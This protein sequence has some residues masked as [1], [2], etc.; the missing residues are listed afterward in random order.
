MIDQHVARASG[1]GSTLCETHGA[2]VKRLSS[3]IM[4]AMG[5]PN[6]DADLTT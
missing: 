6:I 4:S 2:W 3:R 5:G 1:R